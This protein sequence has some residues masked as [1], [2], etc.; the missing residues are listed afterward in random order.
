VIAFVLV[1]SGCVQNAP[2]TQLRPKTVTLRGIYGNTDIS[3]TLCT[4]MQQWPFLSFQQ[5]FYL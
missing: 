4:K 1:E 2:S 5:A 3:R